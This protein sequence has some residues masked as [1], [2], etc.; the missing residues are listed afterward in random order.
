LARDLEKEGFWKEQGI[1]IIGV[2][3]DAVELTEDRQLFRDRM[4][5]I[6]IEQCRSRQAYSLLDAKEIKE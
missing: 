4:E 3:I 2:D 6:G 5:E 1:Q